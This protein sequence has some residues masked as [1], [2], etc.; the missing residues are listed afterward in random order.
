M[1]KPVKF[2]RRFEKGMLL[3]F[4]SVGLFMV[5]IALFLLGRAFCTRSN[6]HY[7]Q[8]QLESFVPDTIDTVLHDEHLN[9]IY[10][11]YN[12]TN[13]V[14][15]YTEEGVFLW[16][17]ATP[18]MRNSG[19]E[20]QD[21]KLIIYDGDA[22]IYDSE[23]GSFLGIEKEENLELSYHWQKEP[24]ARYEEGSF[25]FGSFQVYKALADGT[26]EVVVSRPWWHFIFH[27]WF[28]FGISG[29]GA[30]GMCISIFVE[31]RGYYRAVKKSVVLQSKKTRFLNSYFKITTFVHLIYT[32]LNILCAFVTDWLIIGIIPLAFHMIVSSFVLWGIKS[33]LSCVPEEMYVIDFWGASEIGSF[34][35]AFISVIIASGI[36]G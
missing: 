3:F 29:I 15:V 19:F 21:G 30:L 22:Y 36:A 10:V 13:C 32:A 25:C 27:H 6:N 18:Y 5:G 23:D 17:V 33:R 28:G 35:L 12:D 34:I 24:V 1:T 8:I 16:C 31:K 11:C 4:V 2:H 26:L 20:L 14:N 9:Q 7:K